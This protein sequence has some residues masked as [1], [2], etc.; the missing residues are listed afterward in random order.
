MV[1]KTNVASS[2]A[3]NVAQMV[4]VV[5]HDLKGPLNT[6]Q[7]AASFLA[8]EVIP[9][10]D[11]RRREHEHL[12]IIQRSVD[13][14]SRL[15]RDLLDVSAAR[16]GRFSIKRSPQSVNALLDD[17]LEM[18]RPLAEAKHVELRPEFAV[19][20]PLVFAD[21]E[22]LL[23]VFANVGG[24]AIKFTPAGGRVTI[25]ATFAH[26][27]IEFGVIDTGP[28]IAPANLMLVFDRFWQAEDT[29]DMGSGLGLAIAKA[30]VEG[31]DG[32]IAV[33]SV[34]DSGSNF[35]FTI[36]TVRQSGSSW[37]EA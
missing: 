29:A 5:A 20:M 31:H 21:R 6:I 27:A 4:A 11:D 12:K 26:D 36:P 7:L 23:Q 13:R 16:S 33:T 2:A 22:R 3:T 37:L 18:L 15:I 25:R 32:R 10:I 9:D 1:G 28:G 19:G 8:Q 34:P 24:N 17:A 14:M 35:S 30:I